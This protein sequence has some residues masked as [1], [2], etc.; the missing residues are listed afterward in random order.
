MC[1]VIHQGCSEWQGA[2]RRIP[3]GLRDSIR[4]RYYSA[5][6]PPESTLSKQAV[7]DEEEE[8]E[9]EDDDD[10]DDAWESAG[11]STLWQ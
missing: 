2:R 9:E 7:E 3:A 1:S 5:L 11:L 10:E 8:D 6:H 4:V